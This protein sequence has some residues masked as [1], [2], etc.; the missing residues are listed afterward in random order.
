MYIS[1][2]FVSRI[3]ARKSENLTDGSEGYFILI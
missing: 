1:Q 2:E 3:E